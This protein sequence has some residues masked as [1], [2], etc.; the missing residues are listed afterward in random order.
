MKKELL[1]AVAVPILGFAVTFGVC[2]NKIETCESNIVRIEQN[3]KE[4]DTKIIQQLKEDVADLKEN[5]NKTD[6]ILQSI[7]TK[8]AELNAN[9]S[10]L[11][12]GKIKQGD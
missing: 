3:Y 5:Q 8:L 6:V 9:V 12:G 2:Q 10:L 7:N 11:L 4:A 1:I